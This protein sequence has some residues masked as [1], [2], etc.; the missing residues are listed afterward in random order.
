MTAPGELLT[1]LTVWAALCAYGLGAGM[2]LAR[3]NPDA[4]WRAVARAVWTAGCAF[5]LAHVVCAFQ[6]YHHWSHTEAYLET[7]E[8]AAK[9][10]GWHSGSGLYLN[11]LFAAIW[12]ADTLWQWIA[13]RGCE[14]RPAWVVNAL[15][16]FFLFMIFNGT[17]VFGHGFARWLGVVLCAG[18]G[19]L[20]IRK[21]ARGIAPAAAIR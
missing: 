21:S 6:F 19:V 16:T 8:R 11:Y 14:R 10:T 5:F 9:L 7:A 13:P 3:R 4:E 12:V 1:R 2:M 17:V 20:W 18:L 15:H